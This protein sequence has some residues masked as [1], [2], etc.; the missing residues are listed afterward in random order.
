MIRTQ[1]EE[2]ARTRQVFNSDEETLDFGRMRATD[3][4][5]NTRVILP[6]PGSVMFE[7]ELE[8]KRI[9][10]TKVFDDYLA[11]MTDKDGNQE[12]NLSEDEEE[13]LVSLKKRVAAGELVVCAMGKSGRF[14]LMTMEDYKFSGSK[15]TMADREVD[16]DYV[17]KN[18]RILTHIVPC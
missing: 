11:E 7:M 15:H 10:W 14:A 12:S 1:A 13:G 9:E 16:L 17:R 2:E 3:A 6:K 4:K 8:V 18:Q 5:G